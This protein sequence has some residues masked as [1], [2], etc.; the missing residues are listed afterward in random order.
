VIHGGVV[1]LFLGE[2]RDLILLLSRGQEHYE[3]GVSLRHWVSS[4]AERADSLGA[5]RNP[6]GRNIGLDNRAR[7]GR[8]QY[9]WTGETIDIRMAEFI[10]VSATLSR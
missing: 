6:A 1:W 5:I 8:G 10:N 2:K 9:R 4:F 3:D 7:G